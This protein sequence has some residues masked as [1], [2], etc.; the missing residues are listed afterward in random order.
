MAHNDDI[1][2]FRDAMN[3]DWETYHMV[4]E[5]ADDARLAEMLDEA[6]DVPG[7]LAL[8]KDETDTWNEARSNCF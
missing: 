4:A 6:G 5:C 3:A 2:E 7:A 8:A 1:K